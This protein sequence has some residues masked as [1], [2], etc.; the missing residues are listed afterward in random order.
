MA[1]RKNYSLAAAPKRSPV[2]FLPESKSWILVCAGTEYDFQRFRTHRK[3]GHMAGRDDLVLTLRNALYRLSKISSSRSIN[4]WIRGGLPVWFQYLDHLFDSG[5]AP[6]SSLEDVTTEVLENY[7]SWLRIRPANTETGRHSYSG[8]RSIYSQ[9]KSVLLECVTSGTMRMEAIPHNPFP[10]SNRA[11]AGHLPYTKEE[12]RRLIGCLSSDLV[13]IRNNTLKANMSY[14]MGV[15]FLLLAARTGRN[16]SPLMEITRYALQP[17][18]LKPESHALLTTY[19]RRGNN[20]AVQS[21]RKRSVEVEDAASITADI[22][23]LFYEAMEMSAPFVKNA[24]AEIKNRLWLFPRD[25]RGRYGN[26]IT[27][28]N[29]HSIPQVTARLVKRHSLESDDIDPNTGNPRPFNLTIMRLRKTFASRIWHLTGGDIV[30]TANALG[31]QPRITDT[32]YLAVTPEMTTNHRFVGKCL[33]ADLR[34]KSDDLPTITRLAQEIRVS[35]DEMKRILTGR[36]NTGVGRCSA[37]L[38]G[39]FA[40]KDGKSAC[41]AFLSCFRCPN[42]VVMENDLHRLF[43]FYWLLIKERNILIRNRWH[44]L[45]GWVIREID[46]VI[47]PRFPVDVV[48]NAREEASRNPHPMWRDRAML[49]GIPNV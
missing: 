11:A 8:A 19:K 49:G 30:R 3:T 22:A 1:T 2:A 6:I 15:Y 9:L 34:G 33:E 31:N 37:P 21:V 13:A 7:A 12:M 29:I 38:D 44:K 4:N 47:A 46:Q 39:K 24:P 14:K 48:N 17:H 35:V 5:A 40:P 26:G 25:I 10:N 20:I 42:Q 27:C 28:L 41:T 43:S 18:P 32:H 16:P 45:Y 36:N 23:T